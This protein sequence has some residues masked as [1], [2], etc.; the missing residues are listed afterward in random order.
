M[1][2]HV[3]VDWTK[4]LRRKF[5]KRV[6]VRQEEMCR[7][8]YCWR[9]VWLEGQNRRHNYHTNGQAV[10]VNFEHCDLENY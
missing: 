3:E 7:G 2:C 10:G 9:G 4:P 1:S 6:V 8:T 5:D